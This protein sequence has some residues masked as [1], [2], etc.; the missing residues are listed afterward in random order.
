M[1]VRR[2]RASGREREKLV[3]HVD[4]RH[5]RTASP[6]PQLEQAPV[7][8]ERLVD[9]ADLER[10]VVEAEARLRLHLGRA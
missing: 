8:H 4:E 3:T 6:Q 2:L 5:P 7:E 10:N 9:V 1:H